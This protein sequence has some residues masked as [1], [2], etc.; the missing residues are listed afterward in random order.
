[1]VATSD[2]RRHEF[3]SLPGIDRPVERITRPDK[4]AG[5]FPKPQILNDLALQCYQV[6]PNEIRRRHIC[7]FG[8]DQSEGLFAVTSPGGVQARNSSER[9]LSP[10]RL[11]GRCVQ[12]EAVT[13][14]L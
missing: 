5:A 8:C 14:S 12:A 11:I 13:L 6:V 2:N 4:E 7:G 10:G 1:M 3:V 9:P